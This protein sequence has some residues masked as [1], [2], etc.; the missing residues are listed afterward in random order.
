MQLIIPS[1]CEPRM[2]EIPPLNHVVV[3]KAAAV[4]GVAAV[5]DIE[6]VVVILLIDFVEIIHCSPL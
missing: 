6:V 5:V 2:L 1:F 3:I 4:A